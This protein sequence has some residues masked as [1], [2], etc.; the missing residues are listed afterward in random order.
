M[1]CWANIMSVNFNS[2]NEMTASFNGNFLWGT[3][4]NDS[5]TGDHSGDHTSD[6]TGT[7]TPE[8]T[9]VSPNG[10]TPAEVIIKG[11]ID[12]DRTL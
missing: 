3:D 2:A 11:E 5:D 10:G 7:P 9:K 4:H 8:W 12:T 6:H 1:K